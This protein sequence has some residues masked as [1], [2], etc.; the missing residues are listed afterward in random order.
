MLVIYIILFRSRLSSPIPYFPVSESTFRP[1]PSTLRHK[2]RFLAT[3]SLFSCCL[4]LTL[5]ETNSVA[6]LPSL[7]EDNTT[8]V[9]VLSKRNDLNIFTSKTYHHKKLFTPDFHGPNVTASLHPPS[10]LLLQHG[11]TSLSVASVRLRSLPSPFCL[12]NVAKSLP[13][14]YPCKYLFAGRWIRQVVCR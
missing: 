3:S 4:S 6:I 1:S 13:V 10:P 2:H 14:R 9:T 5:L 11:Y 12:L 7:S 8:R